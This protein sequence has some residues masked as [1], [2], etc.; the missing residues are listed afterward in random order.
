M[1]RYAILARV[2]TGLMLI[3][4]WWFVENPLSGVAF[5]LMLSALSAIRYRIK[6]YHLLGIL[7]TIICICYAFTWL[8]ALLG[9]WLPVI[10]IF[11]DKWNQLEEELL[12]SSFAERGERLKLEASIESSAREMQN[13]A[14]LAEMT[15]RSRIAQD[16]HDHVG[17]E[18]S[19]ASIALQ[20]AIKLY[21]M[22]DNRAED[23]LNQTAKRL[24][25]ASEHLR[26]AVHN[27][28]P[29]RVPGVSTIA[30]I[31]EEFTFCPIS[32][33]ASGDLSGSTHWELLEANLKETLT[34]VTR[35]SNATEVT[36]KLSGN[37]DY[38]R[39]Q[40]TDNG[41]D[42]RLGYDN[43]SAITSQLE[44]GTRSNKTSPEFHAGLGLSGISQRVRAV[45]GSLSISNDNGFTVVCIIP[46]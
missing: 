42:N 31:C 14:R 2:F 33:T 6:A 22:G 4:C 12:R 41:T 34:N 19:G 43:S 10:G 27:L 20:T 32:Y 16:I 40:V 36:V 18:I 28:K 46:K 44:S 9:I 45:G 38:I 11:E 21:S 5:L 25:S 24:E 7:E 29:S 13:A 35:H 23:L 3:A 8:P 37:A 15:E 17:H 1:R 39:M 26:E 30:E